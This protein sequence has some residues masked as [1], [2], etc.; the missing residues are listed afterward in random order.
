[1]YL[2]RLLDLCLTMGGCLAESLENFLQALVPRPCLE[3]TVLG[4]RQEFYS[5]NIRQVFGQPFDAVLFRVTSRAW[6]L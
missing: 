2:W 1:M 3:S 6:P 4:F 5:S